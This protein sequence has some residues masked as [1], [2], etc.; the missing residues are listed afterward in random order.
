VIVA[1]SD[2]ASTGF[3]AR[4]ITGTFHR[5]GTIFPSEAF[6]A[7]RH[8]ISENLVCRGHGVQ[9]VS[10]NLTYSRLLVSLPKAQSDRINHSSELSRTDDNLLR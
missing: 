8:A 4:G 9:G 1:D 2:R 6:A 7:I 5:A 10:V 3:I